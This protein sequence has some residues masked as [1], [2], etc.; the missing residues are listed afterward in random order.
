MATVEPRELLQPSFFVLEI[1]ISKDLKASLAVAQYQNHVIAANIVLDF[2]GARTYL[3]GATSN[4]HRNVMAQY[5]LH[6]FL[7]KDA[8]QKGFKVFDFWGVAPENASVKHAW[9][10]ISRYKRGWGGREISMPGTYDAPVKRTWYCL[11]TLARK[12]RH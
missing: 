7:I 5:A 4:L 6:W 8:K 9:A 12:I 1:L 3:H 10:G 2:N 11:Y